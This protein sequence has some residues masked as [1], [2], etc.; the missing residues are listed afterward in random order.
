MNSVELGKRIKEARIAKKMT[1]SEVVG[2]FITRNMLSQIESGTATPSIKTLAYL[3]RILD[4]PLIQLMP[5]QFMPDQ[6]DDAL[7]VLDKAKNLLAAKNYGKLLELEE[8]YPP[9]FYDEFCAIF[10]YAYLNLSK[11]CLH[12]GDYPKA[13]LYSQKA[14]IYSEKGIYANATVKS[15]SIMILNQAAAMI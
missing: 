6:G 7:S 13:A 8:E 14:A 11:E 12:S 3:S 2:N 9:Q 5:D 10:S 4:V 15:E 1:Q